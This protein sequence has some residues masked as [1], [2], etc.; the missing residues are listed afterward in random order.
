M[1]GHN[2][3]VHMTED[4]GIYSAWLVVTFARRVG[5]RPSSVGGALVLSNGR[6]L[7]WPAP[8]CTMCRS[9]VCHHAA[10]VE[11]MILELHIEE[12]LDA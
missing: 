9:R 5:N 11:T 7:D 8:G 3:S 6:S 4:H 2:Y 10:A 1:V 12:S